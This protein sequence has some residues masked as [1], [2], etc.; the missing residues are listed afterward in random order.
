MNDRKECDKKL[1]FDTKKQAKAAAVQA[2]WERDVDLKIYRCKK[3]SYW[4]L[5][6]EYKI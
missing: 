6:T 4:H 1:T 3:C 2:K 5:A